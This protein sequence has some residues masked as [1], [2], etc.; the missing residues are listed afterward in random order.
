MRYIL[1]LA[2]FMSVFTVQA[3]RFNR[4]TKLF[5]QLEQ[6]E[7]SL[8]KI[9]KKRINDELFD[10]SVDIWLS[11]KQDSITITK[12]LILQ[13]CWMSYINGSCNYRDK[14]DFDLIGLV[15]QMEG[16]RLELEGFLRMEKFWKRYYKEKLWKRKN[17]TPVLIF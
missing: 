13:M 6:Q 8:G 16:N 12:T 1:L 10:K 2:V 4:F 15:D 9:E 7:D 5:A 3:Q 11:L 17:G 14:G